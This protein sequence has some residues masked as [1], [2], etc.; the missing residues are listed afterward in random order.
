MGKVEDYQEM[1]R[2]VDSAKANLAKAEATLASDERQLSELGTEVKGEF[3]VSAGQ[4][5][6]KLSELEDEISIEL[7][8]AGEI[9]AQIKEV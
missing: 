9:L 2:R 1:K 6:K 7:E 8:K 4:L 5:S 3:G